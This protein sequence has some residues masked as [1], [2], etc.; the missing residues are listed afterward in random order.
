MAG[1]NTTY[2]IASVAELIGERG[3]AA[4]LITLLDGRAQTA[5]ALAFVA[6]ISAQSASAHLSKLVDGGLL[7]VQTSGRH[8][9]YRIA[10]P[11]VAHAIEALGVIATRPRQPTG[12]GPRETGDMYRARSCY[13]HLAGRVAVDLARALEDSGVIQP[14]GERD[15]EV[16]RQGASWFK[17]LGIDVDVLRGCR[18][19]FARRCLDWT[20]RKPHIAGG[21][22]AA[23]FSRMQA[24]GWLARRRHTRALRITHRGARELQARLGFTA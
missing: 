23:L 15:Y 16:G 7:S 1:M 19:A 24:L 11:Q 13:D 4:I 6:E 3:R 21:L 5:G 14:R 17:G 22:G 10:D 9:Y 8:R 18:R 20:E 2:P 12:P